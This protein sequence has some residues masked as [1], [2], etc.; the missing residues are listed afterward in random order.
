M[1][2]YKD[3]YSHH[4]TGEILSLLGSEIKDILIPEVIKDT[5]NTIHKPE[6]LFKLFNSLVNNDYRYFN[7][8]HK[9]KSLE[10]T[11][12]DVSRHIAI[13]IRL[14]F[15]SILRSLSKN[16]TLTPGVD[17]AFQV[18]NAIPEL[19]FIYCEVFSVLMENY[20]VRY[21]ILFLN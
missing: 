7:S 16:L 1:N 10:E 15:V 18:K 8:L 3:A 12:I 13:S 21:F 4:T 5:D 2:N 17:C 9:N 20:E 14:F 6:I 11:G 19:T